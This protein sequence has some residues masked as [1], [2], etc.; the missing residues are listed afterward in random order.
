MRPTSL[1]KIAFAALLVLM[2]GVTTG[3]LGGL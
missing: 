3:W 2:F 1:Q